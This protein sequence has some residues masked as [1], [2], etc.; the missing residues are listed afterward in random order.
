MTESSG[1][2]LWFLGL[3]KA[4]SGSVSCPSSVIQVHENT[5]L[6]TKPKDWLDLVRNLQVKIFLMVF[7][8]SEGR[9]VIPQVAATKRQRLRR[10]VLYV[11]TGACQE[12][13]RCVR[14]IS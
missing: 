13:D 12:L 3:Q 4:E 11:K 2:A 10:Y 8:L 9:R 6:S 5:D 14:V 7:T 1:F